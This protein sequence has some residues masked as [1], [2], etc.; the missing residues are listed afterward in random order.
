M[1]LVDLITS[2][3][4]DWFHF[5]VAALTGHVLT[6]RK[7]TVHGSLGDEHTLTVPSDW[8]LFKVRGLDSSSMV[9]LPTVASP[10]NGPLLES[11]VL[12]VNEDANLIWA[13]ERRLDGVEVKTPERERNSNAAGLP[14]TDQKQY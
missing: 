3:S 11:V 14:A 8:S 6:L 1:L 12:G 5:P 2:H 10:L 9:I 13:V 7:V 4:N